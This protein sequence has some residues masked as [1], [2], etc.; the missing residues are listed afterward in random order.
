MASNNGSMNGSQHSIYGGGA[1]DLILANQMA[2]AIQNVTSLRT[3]FMNRMMD[4]RRDYNA[5]CGY[6]SDPID[7][8]LFMDMYQRNEIAAR[9]VDVY[10]KECWQTTPE[11]TDD[12]D[13]NKDTKFEEQWKNCGKYL[14]AEKSYFKS[15]ENANPVW[16][17]C[18]RID[19][20]SRICRYG[21]MILGF[22]DN[23]P[24]IEPVKPRK[25]MKLRYI[26]VFPET[27]AQITASE[28]NLS[29]PRYQHPTSYLVTFNDPRDYTAGG[30]GLSVA[31]QMVH[32]SRII[33]VPS[34]GGVQSHE[35]LGRSA[36]HQ[37]FNRLIDTTKVFGPSAEG[38]W[39]ACFM[40]LS[41]ETHP[42]LGGDVRIDRAQLRDMMDD[43]FNTLD[44]HISLSGMSAK[45]IA[46][47]VSDPSPHIQVIIEAICI[48]LGIP[49]RIFK[50][51]ERGELASSQ[52]DDAWNDRVKERCMSHIVPRII[53]PLV[54]RLINVGVLTSPADDGYMV[55]WPDLTSMSATEKAAIFVQRVTAYSQYVAGNV[56]TIIPPKDLM[57]K[58]DT[59]TDSEADQI[60][61]D[62]AKAAEDKMQE[63][64]DVADEHGMV[65]TPPPGFQHPEPPQPGMP[66]G[67]PGPPTPPVNPV[68]MKPGETLVHPQTGKPMADGGVPSAKDLMSANELSYN[69]YYAWNANPEGHNQYTLSG[70]TERLAKALETPGKHTIASVAEKASIHPQ[71]AKAVLDKLSPFIDRIKDSRGD[72]T[73]EFRQKLRGNS[74]R[75]VLRS[76]LSE[77]GL[78]DNQAWTDNCGG[79]GSGVPGPC[80]QEGTPGATASKGGF[81]GLKERIGALKSR[82]DSAINKIPVI[83]TIKQGIEKAQ[84]KLNTWMTN[85]YGAAATA[86]IMKSALYGPVS[87][88][89]AAAGLK[90][91]GVPGFNDV[92]AVGVSIGVAESVL[93]IGRAA[94]AVKS[95]FTKNELGWTFNDEDLSPE[96]L[97][98]AVSDVQSRFT[99]IMQAYADQ[100]GSEITK[101]LKDLKPSDLKELKSLSKAL[102]APLDDTNDDSDTQ[103][104]SNLSDGSG[105]TLEF[106]AN[107]LN[108]DVDWL[109]LFNQF[110]STGEGGG[111]DP[112]CGKGDSHGS[113][114]HGDS[115]GG[116]HS[117]G[118]VAGHEFEHAGHQ[119]HSLHEAHEIHEIFGSSHELAS[120]AA[121]HGHEAIHEAH[122]VI[123][124][125]VK[126]AHEA[127]EHGG[128][129]AHSPLDA[130]AII[131]RNSYG[132]VLR[133]TVAIMERVPGAR[134][135]GK[136][137]AAL[138]DGATKISERA[139]E[140]LI[141]RY[142]H[143]TA[144][145]I[146]GAGSLMAHS[147]TKAAGLPSHIGKALP[148]Q[149]IIGAI[150]MIAMAE[151][152]K[153]MGLVGKDSKLE[154]GLE[155]AGTW[156]H[157]IKEA[158]SRPLGTIKK[159]LGA[160]GLKTAKGLGKATGK[161]GR[162]VGLLNEGF[163]FNEDPITLSQVEIEKAA[164]E[165]LDELYKEYGDLVKK[166]S[167]ELASPAA[168]KLEDTANQ[169]CATGPGGGIDA[170][171]GKDG[172]KSSDSGSKSPIAKEPHTPP[173][174]GKAYTPNVEA[175][176]NK[177]GITD[178]ARI[179]V[180]A[181]SVPPPPPIGRLPN[182]TE[183]ERQV[184]DGFIKYYEANPKQV[185]HDFL[186]LVKESTK[187]GEPLTFGTD[188]AKGLAVDWNHPNL[189]QQS[190]NRATLNC[191]LHQT[192]NAI[193]KNAFLQ[194]LDTLE[195]GDGIM[196]TVGGCGAGKGYS[197]GKVPEAMA[198]KMA[199]KAVWDSA[200]DQNATENPWIQ[201][202]AEKRG[203]KVTYA[204]VHANPETQWAHP[205]MG[206]VQR[207]GN[208]KD[209]RMVDAKVFAD[210]YV[211]G[212]Q[213]HQAF[214]EKNKDNPNASFVFL[215]AGK[216][217]DGIPK[218]ALSIDRHKLAEFAAKTVREGSAPP[219]VKRGGLVGERIWKDE[220]WGE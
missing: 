182:L 197:L 212:A 189:E 17:Y 195:K 3:E 162:A 89:G 80:K 81:S 105:I 220:S 183:H 136:T 24:L 55:K 110:C 150:P 75:G 44:R 218:E 184:E 23:R 163:T 178:A 76:H 7:P 116:G 14:R 115:H 156:I 36:M 206:V 32:H 74:L 179:G 4:P 209:G 43:F 86:V 34:D 20:L 10:P 148:G 25:G 185:G 169:F 170:T 191:A 130:Y 72:Q 187:P 177:D 125:S 193:A 117:P 145:A 13:P 102:H 100:H 151:V 167:D 157:A 114:G 122:K 98:Q 70:I 61:E 109:S 134:G 35:V 77:M 8:N 205:E 217:I 73:P 181:M 129:G 144:G 96:Q 207:A 161:A 95:A 62:A 123:H 99:E 172:E 192:A 66:G 203:L 91:P 64:Q 47:V 143:S 180:P 120:H 2:K 5:E 107:L 59:M 141:S 54:D 87:I 121:E 78:T 200:G 199:S 50:G 53:V 173:P 92:L 176:H 210:S 202:E 79:E 190:R 186:Q 18:K 65:P 112:T 194:H 201:K 196:V 90:L 132:P 127:I 139:V 29:S 42:Q 165:F 138:H 97:K 33:H 146:L 137:I 58:F 49:I 158:I 168:Q 88:A 27:L 188:D 21:V 204:Y 164:K 154:K 28:N 142:G 147:V 31:T 56:E 19:A 67:P 128:H 93:Q 219:H 118:H 22:D 214:Y 51:S 135:V 149:S 133:A 119:A 103:Q 124:E 63:Q 48:L 94:K 175:D 152:G 208:P 41:L 6:P 198:M 40:A 126:E 11:I 52:D 69:V 166:H 30:I 38:Y 15:D 140:G 37:C 153:R 106:L 71:A 216:R 211:L 101:A 60:L 12:E 57:T 131:A 83:G 104:T 1:I 171:C 39:R 213:N 26:R 9:V 108:G 111:V 45:T 82:I 85:R 113:G 215:A 16:D 174:P 155:R 84:G 46:P 160:I 68:K 159:E